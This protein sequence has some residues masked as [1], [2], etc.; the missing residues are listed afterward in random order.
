MKALAIM[1]G[2]LGSLKGNQGEADVENEEE[3]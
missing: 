3:Q 2:S 1:F